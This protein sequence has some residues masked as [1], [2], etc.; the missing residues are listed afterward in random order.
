MCKNEDMR[1]NWYML[2]IKAFADANMLHGRGYKRFLLRVSW[3]ELIL[4]LARA[5]DYGKVFA[6]K[7]EGQPQ[8]VEG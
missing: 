4:L 8:V 7:D 3:Y 2:Q 5:T 1:I 6:R